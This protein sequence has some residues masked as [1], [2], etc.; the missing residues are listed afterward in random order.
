MSDKEL[1]EQIK[2]AN[3]KILDHIKNYKV[4]KD[5][6][7]YRQMMISMIV[8]QLVLMKRYFLHWAKTEI[9]AAYQEGI[10]SAYEVLSKVS[11]VEKT[12]NVTRMKKVLIATQGQ[13]TDATL[14]VGRLM[15]DELMQVAK[16]VKE[17]GL[18]AKQGKARFIEVATKKGVAFKDKRGRRI[19]L[20][21]YADMVSRTAKRE[22]ANNGVIQQTLDSGRDLVQISSH[23]TTCLVCVVYEGRVY[24]ISGKSKKYPKLSEAFSNGYSTL[25]P[26][27]LHTLMP[28]VVEY[29]KTPEETIKNSNRPFEIR[30]KDK[31]SIERYTKDQK[32]KAERRRDRAA[33]EKARTENPD[34]TA[35]SF[36]GY[37]TQRRNKK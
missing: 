9:P 3:D 20:D 21:A 24:S 5:Y 33:W 34:T 18:T 27:C 29:D 23:A 26:N 4:T 36:S 8:A 30:D 35:K 13:V 31:A 10:N 19:N 15:Q 32:V 12:V 37:R 16:E 17:Q 14:Y 2:A 25:H 7:H 1:L 11:D 6:T 22:A 28:Y